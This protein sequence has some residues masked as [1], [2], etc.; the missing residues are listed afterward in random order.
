M[1]ILDYLI[2]NKDELLFS[3]L[4]L[5]EIEKD[6]EE[7]IDTTLRIL[8][9]YKEPETWKKN[10]EN[11]TPTPKKNI[12]D[13]KQKDETNNESYFSN[14]KIISSENKGKENKQNTPKNIENNVAFENLIPKI[15]LTTIFK[16]FFSKL[17]II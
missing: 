17:L 11:S 4:N 12:D 7:L 6:E 10:K 13:I 1:L 8:Q 14:K 5:Y 16:V 9:K 2:K 3:T 15:T